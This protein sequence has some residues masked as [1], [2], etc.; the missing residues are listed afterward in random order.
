MTDCDVTEC[1]PLRVFDLTASSGSESEIFSVSS[2][3]C[4]LNLSLSQT[5]SSS[6]KRGASGTLFSKHFKRAT[7]SMEG[8][9]VKAVRK[10]IRS[11]P[12]PQSALFKAVPESVRNRAPPSPGGT[13]LQ[14][15]ATWPSPPSVPPPEVDEMEVKKISDVGRTESTRTLHGMHVNGRSPREWEAAL[16]GK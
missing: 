16:A 10:A 7:R 5:L 6:E 4:R 15:T 13:P 3:V 11:R 14:Q 8:P 9:P 12:T 2:S 1:V